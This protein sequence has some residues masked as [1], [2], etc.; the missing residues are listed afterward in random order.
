MKILPALLA[1]ASMMV[2]APAVA[3]SD[4]AL[5][6]SSSG[7]FTVTATISPATTDNVRVF[8]LDDFSFSGSEGG[9]INSQEKPFC[10]IRTPSGGGVGVTISSFDA[11]A[12]GSPF[13]V[14]T[15]GGAGEIQLTIALYDAGQQIYFPV[16][17][18]APT[19]VQA[20]SACTEVAGDP[21]LGLMAIQLLNTSSANPGN[22]SNSF[23]ITVAP[24]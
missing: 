13:V 24:E 10:I 20:A 6:H 21:A 19:S 2:A 18:G 22:Y 1:C 7:T 8:G 15:P 16:T 5:G 11:P 4:G 3:S 14:K 12:A 17:Q 9:S 23:L